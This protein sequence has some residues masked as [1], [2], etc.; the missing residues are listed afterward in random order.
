MASASPL[1]PHMDERGFFFVLP[2]LGL[3]DPA[4]EWHVIKAAIGRMRDVVELAVNPSIQT[5]L[6]PRGAFNDTGL[7]PI[8]FQGAMW[9]LYLFKPQSSSNTAAPEFFSVRLKRGPP[10]PRFPSTKLK[11]DIEYL[12]WPMSA[13]EEQMEAIANPSITELTSRPLY[14]CGRLEHITKWKEYEQRAKRDVTEEEALRGDI[15]NADWDKPLHQKAVLA[16]AERGEESLMTGVD[17]G[18]CIRIHPAPDGD[19]RS[20]DYAIRRRNDRNL[21]FPEESWKT[22]PSCGSRPDGDR[23]FV[24]QFRA[25]AGKEPFSKEEWAAIRAA[26]QQ[27]QEGGSSGANGARA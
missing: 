14:G 22:L 17:F 26:E 21:P 24:N 12:F 11:D 9:I 7:V 10:N 18:T 6:R 3:P 16:A 25:H 8:E 27:Q 15:I 20:I 5:P 13:F 1:T 23:K 2:H 4:G 19:Y